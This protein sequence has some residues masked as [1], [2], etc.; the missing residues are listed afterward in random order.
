MIQAP[1]G[2]VLLS[3]ILVAYNRFDLLERALNSLRDHPPPFPWETIVVDNASEEDAREFVASRFSE[4]VVLRSQENEGFGRANNRGAAKARGKYLLFL[5]SDAEVLE[6]CLATMVAR[7][8]GDPSIG[9]L[10][11]LTLNPDRSFQ[12]SFGRPISLVGEWW[13]KNRAPRREARRFGSP[14]SRGLSFEPGWVSGSCLATRRELF[15]GGEVF[16]PSLFLYFED[17]ELCLRI[18]QAGYRV[19]F[20]SAAAIIHLGGGS[21][22][23][24]RGRV[25][26]EYRRSQLYLYRKWGGGGQLLGLRLYLIARF[27]FGW[28][29]G[30]LPGSDRTQRT[31]AREILRQAIS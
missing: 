5:N 8:E 18:K 4:V 10:G 6:G 28:L 16:D 1:S 26:V 25:A 11:P 23:P 29:A 24:L 7:L 30:W 20:D 9:I 22:P 31:N 13:Q 17:H 19:V 3:V 14:P 12:L 15:P 2:Q 21:I 27:T